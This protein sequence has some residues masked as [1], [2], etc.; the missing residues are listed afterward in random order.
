MLPYICKSR[1]LI[2]VHRIKCTKV[3]TN[4]NDVKFHIYLKMLQHGKKNRCWTGYIYFIWYSMLHFI[5]ITSKII[6]SKAGHEL[7]ITNLSCKKI[8]HLVN[9]LAQVNFLLKLSPLRSVGSNTW[10]QSFPQSNNINYLSSLH[11]F[12][13][14]AGRS[15][16]VS[17]QIDF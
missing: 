1:H 10:Q 5:T 11:K 7:F 16:L 6:P 12:N 4:T 8:E 2:K 9:V 13:A 14:V 17:L 3:V 15:R